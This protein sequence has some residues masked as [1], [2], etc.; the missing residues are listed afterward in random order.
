MCGMRDD[1]VNGGTG[2]EVKWKQVALCAERPSVI[3]PIAQI[4]T[5]FRSFNGCPLEPSRVEE[6][7]RVVESGEAALFHLAIDLSQHASSLSYMY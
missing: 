2:R 6:S 4:F 7:S 1:A 3:F 5:N